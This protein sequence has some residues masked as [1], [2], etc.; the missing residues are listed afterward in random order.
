M[1]G[2][3]RPATALPGIDTTPLQATRASK[4]PEPTRLA[5][6][7]KRYCTFTAWG[8]I[9]GRPKAPRSSRPA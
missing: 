3:V 6:K 9:L 7:R 2:L 5:L 4:Q 8:G 1:A